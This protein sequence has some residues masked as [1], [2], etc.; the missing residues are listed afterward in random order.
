MTVGELL[1]K[2]YRKLDDEV[3]G[4]A[5]KLWSPDELIDDYANTVQ[6]DLCRICRGLLVSTNVVNEVLAA[7]TI[8]LAGTAGT[9]NSVS[10][11]GVVITNGAVPFNGTI[12]QTAADLAASINAKTSD[13][14]YDA[15]AS[16]AIV[17][18]RAKSGTGSTP[19][20]YVITASLT[21]LTATIANMSGGSA[22]CRLY[23]VPGQ[24]VYETSPYILEIMRVKPSL[25]SRPLEKATTGQLDAAWSGW[26]GAAN[27]TPKYWLNDR[28]QN[29]VSIVPPPSV[30][31]TATLTAWRLPLVKL[32]ASKLTASPEIGLQYHDDLIP[33][34]MALAFEK[35]DEE[36]FRPNLSAKYAS[37]F[38]SKAE[39]IKRE[40]IA[41][42]IV[43]QTC[44][45]GA[46]FR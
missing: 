9:V 1:K 3:G 32:S 44:S 13:P 28:D 31:D 30:K 5:D 11:N 40:L 38:T 34:I 23:L 36:T 7:G 42:G 19:N 6:D 37:Q 10:V 33:G 39:L 45:P 20:G 22:I 14:D 16:G 12:E 8:T 35:N 25:Q 15:S 4:N 17:T 24:M 2:L 46:A 18:I 21:T 29:S 26:E 41:K 27:G 43:S